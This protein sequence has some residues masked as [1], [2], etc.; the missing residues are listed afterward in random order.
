MALSRIVFRLPALLA[1]AAVA[2]GA[3]AGGARARDGIEYWEVQDYGT[4][5]AVRADG[6]DTYQ[7]TDIS[8]LPVVSDEAYVIVTAS[9]T[10][11]VDGSPGHRTLRRLSGLPPLCDTTVQP[12]VF[13]VFWQTFHEHYPFFDAKGM[14]WNAIRDIWRDRANDAQARGDDAALF[15]ALRDTVEPLGDAH[16][17]ISAGTTG[18]F[19]SGRPGTVVP[20][21]E[22]DAKVKTFVQ[23]RDLRDH[24]LTDY[25]RGR[26]SYADLPDR[27][28]YGYLRISGFGGYSDTDTFAADSAALDH[29]LADILTT[30]RRARL[31][32]LILDLRVNGGGSDSLGLRLA[33]WF[34]DRPYFAYAKKTR[35]TAPQP[36]R[37]TPSPNG[38][39]VPIAILTGGST[40]SAGETFTQA[41]IERP[42][43]TVRIGEATQGVFS[44]VLERKLP[45][46]G[47][48]DWWFGLPNELFLDGGGKT[49]DGTGIPPQLPEPVFTDEE[50]ARGADSAFD[51]AVRWLAE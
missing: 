9:A 26:I 12:S 4:V 39:P 17:M 14:D 50:F 16:V 15:A 5:L 20:G 22:L 30:D 23:H 45:G 18:H 21:P 38:F 42:A 11:R 27:P 40:V 1:V 25:A 24:P 46:P 49:F 41:M 2:I 47:H 3:A 51:R 35:T 33:G 31:R 28:D 36:Q 10:L 7:V 34:T 29:A 13:D 6:F 32:G 48:G 43:R 44:D 8:C 19:G 37:I